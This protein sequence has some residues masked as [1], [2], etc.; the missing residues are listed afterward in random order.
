MY[1]LQNKRNLCVFFNILCPVQLENSN[2]LRTQKHSIE[3]RCGSTEE[4]SLNEPMNE[5]CIADALQKTSKAIQD[6]D[7]LLS[8]TTLTRNSPSWERGLRKRKTSF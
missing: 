4:E 2:L 5:N 7:A 8:A 3:L 1:K 6:I